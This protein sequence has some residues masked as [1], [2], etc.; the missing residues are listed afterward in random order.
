[1]RIPKI[2]ST[3][4][5]DL[6]REDHYHI[7]YFTKAS[8]VDETWMQDEKE[9]D[10]YIKKA[11][12]LIRNSIEYKDYISFLKDEIDMNQCAL[13]SNLTREDVSLEIHHA[14]F[15]LYDL[16]SIVLTETRVN[17]IHFTIFDVANKVMKLHYDGLVG[18]I[19]LTI[20]V[21]ELVHN[22]D[23]FIPLDYVHGNI[24]GFYDKYK[25]Y[26][27]QEQK[28]LLEKNVQQTTLLNKEK[29]APT[30][31]ERRYT[32][33]SVDGFDFPKL[34]KEDG[35]LSESKLKIDIKPQN[36]YEEQE[37]KEVIEPELS[38]QE[39]FDALSDAEEIDLDDID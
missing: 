37:D 31:L 15:T 1:M 29:Y 2:I 8:M 17:D 32:Y 12:R 21:H 3:D 26:F 25:K 13:L 36:G 27:T 38:L 19:P 10:K 14:P 7:G 6:I 34:I 33:L 35:T 22:G 23:I 24:K 28:E 30:V 11:E 9:L 16:T 18:L 4:S 39:A 20:T 5:K